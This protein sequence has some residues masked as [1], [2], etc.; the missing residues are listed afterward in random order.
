MKKLIFVLIL[1]SVTNIYSQKVN[2]FLDD[3]L[4]IK[5]KKTTLSFGDFK[6][7]L[8]DTL[9]DGKYYLYNLRRNDSAKMSES[10]LIMIGEY[11][12]NLKNGEFYQYVKYNEKDASILRRI[13]NYKNG[14]FDGFQGDLSDYVPLKFY[15]NFKDGKLNGPQLVMCKYYVK[16][17]PIFYLCK[18]L[19][20][21]NDTL[22]SWIEFYNNE[23]VYIRVN[24]NL[25]HGGAIAY[26]YNIKGEITRKIAFDEGQILWIENYDNMIISEKIIYNDNPYGGAT[27]GFGISEDARSYVIYNPIPLYGCIIR[28]DKNGDEIQK[29][30]YYNGKIENK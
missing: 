30:N 7:E 22:V 19:N 23:N 12:N 1:I 25:L 4:Y 18:I 27:F 3:S 28:Y 24:G 20:Y 9:P 15:Y 13:E 14:I 6:V 29:I 8:K 16:R 5:I 17:K 10:N 11:K 26:E 21:D 2:I